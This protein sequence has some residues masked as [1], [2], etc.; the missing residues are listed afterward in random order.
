MSDKLIIITSGGLDS[1]TLVYDAYDQSFNPE[2]ISFDYGQRHSKELEHAASI[3]GRL[4]FHHDIID[5][6]GLTHLLAASGSSLVSDTAVPEG[7]YAEDTMKATVVPNRNMIMLSIAAGI[8]VARGACGVA[9]AVHA[10]DH[11]IYPDCRPEFIQVTNEAIVRGNLGFSSFDTFFDG[12][13]WASAI[14]APYLRKTKTD[15]AYRAIELNVPIEDTWSC[16][17][18][19]DIHCGKCG[20]CVERLEAIHDASEAWTEETGRVYTD[21]TRYEDV[22]FWKTAIANGPTAK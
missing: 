20:T 4:G 8:A 11:F 6:T 2:L 22:E 16:Y 12:D 5:L 19:G 15:I 14:K 10:G 7:H 13:E 9:T 1:T 17:K 3:S 21:A 18:G